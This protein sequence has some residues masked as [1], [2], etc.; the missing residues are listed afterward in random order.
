MNFNYEVG[1]FLDTEADQG[2]EAVLPLVLNKIKWIKGW[3]GAVKWISISRL[4]FSSIQKLTREPKP[5]CPLVLNKIKRI[6]GWT[7]ALRLFSISRLDF[8]SI[9]K[10]THGTEAVYPPHRHKRLACALVLQE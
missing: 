9:Q 7:G 10:L 6:K 5:F 4:D 8:S 3:T 1:F 2:I